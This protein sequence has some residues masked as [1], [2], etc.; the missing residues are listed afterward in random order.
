MP[1]PDYQS[2]MLPVLQ[3]A[4][5]GETR[6]PLAAEIIADRLGLTEKERFEMLPSG[7]QRLLYN[8]IHWAKFYMAKAGLI[9]TPKRGYF[10]VSEAGKK[11]LAT[12]P[13][14]ITLETLLLYPQFLEFYRPIV[15]TADNS[16]NASVMM[17]TT[18]EEQI[19]SAHKI[20]HTA[21]CADILQHLLDQSPE[22]FE[23]LIVTLL[24]A[25]GY[26]GTHEDAARRI[27]KSGDGGVDGVIDQDRLGL[28]RIYVQAKRY[29]HASVGRP[30]LQ[31]FVGSLVGLGAHKGIFVTTSDFSKQAREY[32]E[33][34]KQRIIL[35]DGQK[36]ADLMIEYGV[37]VRVSSVVEV[38]KIDEAFFKD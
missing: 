6:V 33:N 25:M 37:G 5:E 29:T 9:L 3:L 1:I 27:G 20:L 28:D 15:K 7:R 12:Q 19:A 34:I 24:L 8:R 16:M 10:I 32:A 35:V 18:P 2:L 21:L 26:G 13:H 14:S 31:A 22:F 4:A 11:L 23:D 17:E 30:E 36:L 38:K